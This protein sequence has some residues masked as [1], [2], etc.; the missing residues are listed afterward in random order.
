MPSSSSTTLAHSSTGPSQRRS[1]RMARGFLTQA[2]RQQVH[3]LGHAWARAHQNIDLRRGKTADAPVLHGLQ[4]CPARNVLGTALAL[5]DYVG[6][7][8][9]HKLGAELRK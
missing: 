5:N 4:A 7:C 8:A 2:L 9:Q 1:W 3:G 6:R